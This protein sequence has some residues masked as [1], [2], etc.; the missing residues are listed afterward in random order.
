VCSVRLRAQE[1]A[2][3]LGLDAQRDPRPRRRL[4]RLHRL[5]AG[6]AEDLEPIGLDV[7]A[8]GIEF[9][10]FGLRMARATAEM[11]SRGTGLSLGD[12][13]CLALAEDVAGNAV[14]TDARGRKPAPT[15]TSP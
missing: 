11:W 8:L 2:E 14:T 7:E 9:G 5:I 1:S 4:H 3:V 10:E 15:S 6:S 13:A 12:R